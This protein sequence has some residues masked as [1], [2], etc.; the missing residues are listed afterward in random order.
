ML[1]LIS[2]KDVLTV[3]DITSKEQGRCSDDPSLDLELVS[4]ARRGGLGPFIQPNQLTSIS[5]HLSP[6]TQFNVMAVCLHGLTFQQ[7]LCHLNKL[8]DSIS[9]R[10]LIQE[11][12]QNRDHRSSP[13]QA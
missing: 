10:D 5:F 3:T 13:C 1:I 2:I 4:A 8:N 6:R 7:Q 9:M 11:Q 12:S